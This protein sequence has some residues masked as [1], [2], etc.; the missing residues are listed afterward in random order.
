MHRA[1]KYRMYPTVAQ[2]A[3]L[4][5]DFGCCRY[6]YNWGLRL[7][8]DTY[9]AT[10]KGFSGYDLLYK[11]TTLKRSGEHDW[12]YD[13]NNQCMQQSL[14]NLRGAFTN[15]FKRLARFPN[16]KSRRSK[17]SAKYLLNIKHRIG[18]VRI[19]KLGW[20]KTRNYKDIA[21]QGK[22][23]QFVVSKTSSG[24]YYCSVLVDTGE[25]LPKEKDGKVLGLDVGCRH[26]VVTSDGDKTEAIGATK[27]Y[28]QRLATEQRKLS[29]KV[30]G[31][32]RRKKQIIRLARIHERIANIRNNF[33]HHLTS[34]LAKSE[35]QVFAIEDLAVRNMVKNRKLAKAI[36]DAS[37]REFRRQLA[38]KSRWS[39]KKVIVV[40]RVFPSTKMCHAC[41]YV[42][43]KLPLSERE[44]VCPSCSTA[45]DRDINA[46][47]NIRDEA[48]CLMAGGYSVSG[49][50]GRVR[51]VA[52]AKADSKALTREA[53]SS[54][55][56]KC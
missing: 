37:F 34:A 43:K 2:E 20:V 38:Y 53:L 33:I 39:G 8:K 30:K 7:W 1:F 31:S 48:E 13:A 21:L 18:A 52:G 54:N 9:E 35:N 50:G 5:I 19:P 47:L 28:E 15:F 51:L 32:Q 24:K 4:A 26:F 27:R 42:V 16:F 40:D 44:W 6:V 23:K 10:G 25:V 29:R 22:I 45:H 12:L 46:S 56:T 11:L 49:R 14:L 17:Q 3:Q 41:R 36:S 55:T